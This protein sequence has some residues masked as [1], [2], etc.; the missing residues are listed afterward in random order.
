MLSTFDS[1]AVL[2]CKEE[3]TAAAGSAVSSDYKYKISVFA[4]LIPELILTVIGSD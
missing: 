2:S 1:A 4:N 3:M